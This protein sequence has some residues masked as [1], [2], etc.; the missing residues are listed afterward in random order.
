MEL[1]GKIYQMWNPDVQ[2][3]IRFLELQGFKSALVGNG[4]RWSE[5]SAHPKVI[6]YDGGGIFPDNY[7]KVGELEGNHIYVFGSSRLEKF[8]KSYDSVQ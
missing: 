6:I 1:S 5:S 3:G 2:E 8:L 4:F 7:S